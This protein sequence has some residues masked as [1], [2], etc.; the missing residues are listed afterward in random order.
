MTDDVHIFLLTLFPFL[1]SIS[2]GLETGAGTGIGMGRRWRV[3]LDLC[4]HRRSSHLLVCGAFIEDEDAGCSRQQG[5]WSWGVCG[6]SVK[7]N[8]CEQKN[9]GRDRDDAPMP[10]G[11]ELPLAC[12]RCITGLRSSV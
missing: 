8:A 7:R 2:A 4:L 12:P 9:K 6:C 3:R 1:F 11:V 10:E 5:L